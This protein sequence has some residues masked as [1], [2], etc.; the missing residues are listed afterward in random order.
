MFVW[1]C[2][3]VIFL[4]LLSWW[5]YNLYLF[6]LHMRGEI[7]YNRDSKMEYSEGNFDK[8]D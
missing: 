5:F 2:Q 3:V 1:I 6:I 7:F 8:K 4:F